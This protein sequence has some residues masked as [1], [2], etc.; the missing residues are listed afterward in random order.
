MKT[1]YPKVS[2]PQ[3]FVSVRRV[4]RL[5]TRAAGGPRGPGAGIGKEGSTRP[6]PRDSAFSLS[7]VPPGSQGRVQSKTQTLPESEVGQ[8]HL[9]LVSLSPCHFIGSPIKIEGGGAW[10]AQSAE[11]LTSAQ[12]MNSRFVDSS[13]ALGSVL[14]ARSLD[15]KSTRLNSS[16]E[17]P[18]R[19][20]SSA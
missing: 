1:T 9:G 17:I 14:T 19:M 20:P 12:V 18:S 6:L 11:R 10:G 4:L 13:P 8:K 15:R 7:P 2:D 5:L 3:V 16:H